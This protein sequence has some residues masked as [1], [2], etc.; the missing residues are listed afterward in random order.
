[1]NDTDLRTLT[2]ER[3]VPHAPA[4]VWRALTQSALIE[5]WLMS[6]DFQPVVGHRFNLRG[7][8]GGV[9]DCEVLAIE[10]NKTLSY[11]WNFKHAD[12]AFDGPRRKGRHDPD[13]V[14]LKTLKGEVVARSDSDLSLCPVRLEDA[15]EPAIRRGHAISR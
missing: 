9:L 12:A 10:P 11:T 2:V 15:A 7:D 13:G 14:V 8:W 6:N 4:K 3:V 1:M 5:D